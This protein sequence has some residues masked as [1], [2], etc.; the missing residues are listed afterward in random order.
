MGMKKK[1]IIIGLIV[2]FIVVVFSGC[3]QQDSSSDKSDNDTDFSTYETI[4][5]VLA[6]ADNIE[7]MYYEIIATITMDQYGTQ[8]ANMKIW[9]KKPYL[10][11]EITSV[12]NGIS[13]TIKVIQRPEGTYNY[14]NEKGK[15]VLSDLN[16]SFVTSLQYFDNEMIKKYINNQTQTNYETELID[17]KKASIIQY[18]PINDS[19][20]MAIKIWIWNEKGVPLKAT[21]DMNLEEIT[22][23]MEFK[24]NNYSFLDIP[25]NTFNVR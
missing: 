3:T 4:Q 5:T 12:T 6:K 22:M 20:P 13:N 1:L 23:L 18:N 24:F 10:K 21:F 11:A 25:D 9:Q 14:D 2:L 17:G 7:S 16:E 8:N 19:Y 15:Y